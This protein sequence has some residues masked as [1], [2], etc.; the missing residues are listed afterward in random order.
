MQLVRTGEQRRGPMRRAGRLFGLGLILLVFPASAL[1]AGNEEDCGTYCDDRPRCAFCSTEACGSVYERME[2]FGGSGENYSACRKAVSVNLGW[3]FRA[4][5]EPHHRTLVVALS[6]DSAGGL[7]WFC[8]DNAHRLE[9]SVLCIS[10][11]GRAITRSKTLANNTSDLIDLMEQTSGRRPTVILIGK[12]MGGCKL[13]HAV[14]GTKGASDARLEDQAINL[15]VGVDMSCSPFRH[16][17]NGEDDALTF[18][19]NVRELLVFYQ[20]NAGAQTGHRA[21][22]Q[23]EAPFEPDIHVDVNA[24]GFSLQRE[25][26]VDLTGSDTPP[27]C[28]DAD[29]GTI[30][31]CAAVQDALVGLI[32]KRA[33]GCCCCARGWW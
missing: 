12:S 5:P 4:S 21:Y 33:R 23:P 15:F 18:S 24:D 13:H 1:R 28:V 17:E 9:E 27:M 19:T 10:S 8:E 32:N 6:G 16:W 25:T 2:F 31:D 22:R 20:Q 26:R 3:P 14:T 30:D 7:E 29:H 11:Y